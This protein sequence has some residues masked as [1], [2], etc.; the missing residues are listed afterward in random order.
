MTAALL[1]IA[2]ALAVCVVFAANDRWATKR[3]RRRLSTP[4]KWAH[5]TRGASRCEVTTSEPDPP[6]TR[7]RIGLTDK[8][9]RT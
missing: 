6:R 7:K 8:E 3:H 2:W 1:A 5:L 4:E 9:H